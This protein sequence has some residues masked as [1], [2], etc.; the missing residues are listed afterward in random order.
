MRVVVSVMGYKEDP[1]DTELQSPDAH[2]RSDQDDGDRGQGSKALSCTLNVP[3]TTTGGNY[4]C[5]TS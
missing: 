2:G 4:S 3:V 5:I 1:A